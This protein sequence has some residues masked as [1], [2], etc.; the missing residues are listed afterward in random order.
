M[1]ITQVLVA[2]HRVMLSVFDQIER[3]LPSLTTLP[4]VRMLATIIEGMLEGHGQA[5]SELAY[6]ALDHV[7]EDRGQLDRLHEEHQEIDSS[8]HGVHSATSFADARRLLAA[9]ILASRK[10]FLFEEQLVFPLLERVLGEDTLNELTSAM[11]ERMHLSSPGSYP[12]GTS[13]DCR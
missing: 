9:A 12:A 1:K 6:L 5:E 3:A 10:H 13:P 2:E 8:L 11:I 4:E 7:L